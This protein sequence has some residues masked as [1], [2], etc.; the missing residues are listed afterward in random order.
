[1]PAMMRSSVD[2]P[3]PLTPSTPILASGIEGEIDV[4]QDLLAARIGLGQALHVID[5]LARGHG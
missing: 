5:E 4:L 2:L 1:M 3:E